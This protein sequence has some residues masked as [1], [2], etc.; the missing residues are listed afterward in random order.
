MHVL[1]MADNKAKHK[2]QHNFANNIYLNNGPYSFHCDLQQ[3]IE[4]GQYLV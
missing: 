1:T 4:I 2:Q 3:L